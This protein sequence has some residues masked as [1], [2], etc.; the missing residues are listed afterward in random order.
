[1]DLRTKPINESI[2]EAYE[3]KG[4]VRRVVYEPGDGTRYELLIA[5]NPGMPYTSV[6]VVLLNF[7]PPRAM[8]VSPGGFL[9]P[10]DVAQYMEARDKLGASLYTLTE[11]IAHLTGCT[12]FSLEELRTF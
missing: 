1:M 2:K 9:S 10:D 11:I 4:T 8:P 5:P 12:T 3:N 6:V 7:D